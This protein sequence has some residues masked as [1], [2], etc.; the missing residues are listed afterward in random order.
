[1]SGTLLR[2]GG[3]GGRRVHRSTATRCGCARS[4][5]APLGY[6]DELRDSDRRAAAAG[7]HHDRGGLP[8]GQPPR[9]GLRR[10]GGRSA[11][12]WPAAAVDA[13]VSPG[14][15]VFHWVD[16]GPR[17]GHRC[18]SGAAARVAARVGVPRAGTTCARRTSRPA[19]RARP[20]SR[21]STRCCSTRRRR[22]ATRRAQPRRH[23]QPHGGRAA[24]R[25]CSGTTSGPPTRCSTPRGPP[26]P[27]TGPAI[28]D[29][30]ASRRPDGCTPALLDRGCS[31]SRTTRR[32]RRSRQG[33]ELFHAGYLD[34]GWPRSTSRCRPTTCW[35]R[36]T[37]S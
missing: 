34:A 17:P 36:S 23:R 9:R 13:V 15:T 33:K 11:S 32:R 25:R 31:P 2:R 19:G 37:P 24:A 6:D 8:A 21:R 7:E 18:N 1:M 14:Q 3:R 16:D 10:G 20:W 26:L 30:A 12:S 5:T 22:A 29:G 28:V 27:R 4:G 35:P